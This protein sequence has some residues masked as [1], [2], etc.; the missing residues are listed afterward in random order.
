MDHR[1]VPACQARQ[2]RRVRSYEAARREDR[3]HRGQH[4]QRRHEVR[5]GAHGVEED[6]VSVAIANANIYMPFAELVDIE[7]EIERLKK[8]EDKLK[9]EIER[10]EKMLSN[11][12]FISKA[13]QS[14][15]DE[16]K[17]KQVK[18]TQLMKQVKDQLA[19]LTK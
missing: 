11:E 13:P 18:Y 19:H 3:P 12:K 6:A 8:E 7:K 2:G 15:V 1:R 17:E 10:V 9:K 5:F 14:K 16:E 4:V